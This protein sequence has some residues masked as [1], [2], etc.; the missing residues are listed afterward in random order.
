M[1]NAVGIVPS[2]GLHIVLD[3]DNTLID[4]I[5]CQTSWTGVQEDTQFCRRKVFFRPGMLELL[6]LC[7]SNF[8]SVSIWTAGHQDWLDGFLHCLPQ[9][10][11]TNFLFLWSR[12]RTRPVYERH[13]LMQTRLSLSAS[14]KPLQKMWRTGKARQVGMTRHNTLIVDDC[15]QN[16]EWNYGNGIE[17]APFND[18]SNQDD[19][20][21]CV[22]L[23][24]LHHL[25]DMVLQ[26]VS[27]RTLEK[28]CW[29][30]RM[31]EKMRRD[32]E[33]DPKE[34]E[35]TN[36][37]LPFFDAQ[38]HQFVQDLKESS[39]GLCHMLPFDACRSLLC[40]KRRTERNSPRGPL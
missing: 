4:N 35:D 13:S 33:E 23:H 25:N 29:Y 6:R 27:V 26:G 28:R 37:T 5:H 9:D 22:L 24:Y 14:M 20:A 21:L 39:I 40:E 30:A 8:A 3:L 1:S 15:R 38:H 36:I 17:I 16:F 31:M 2:K 32:P 11:R 19:N 7:Q 34:E 12:N 10:L 18:P